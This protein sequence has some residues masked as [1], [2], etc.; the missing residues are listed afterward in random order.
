MLYRCWRYLICSTLCNTTAFGRREQQKFAF[1]SFSARRLTQR[2]KEKM[3]ADDE[4]GDASFLENFDPDAA[5]RQYEMEQKQQQESAKRRKLSLEQ[6]N[7]NN[8]KDDEVLLKTLMHYFGYN[9]F[10]GEQLPVIQALLQKRDC[11]VFWPTGFGKSLCYSLPPLHTNS[12]ALVVSPLISLMQDQVHKLNS[13]TE[14]KQ[15]AAFLGS[16]QTDPTVERAALAGDFP[17]VF[18]TPEKLEALYLQQLAPKLC[19][20]AID[21]AHCVSE[22]GHD[23]RPSYRAVGQQLRTNRN[24]PLSQVPIVALTATATPQ[25]QTDIVQSLHLRPNHLVATRSLDRP[26]LKLIV[27]KKLPGGVAANLVPAAKSW[28]KSNESTLIYAPTRSMVQDICHALQANHIPAAMYHA[29]M[30]TADRNTT[31]QQFLTSKLHILVATTAFGMGIDK[32]DIRRVVHYSPPKTVEEY[33]QQLGRA[34]RDGLAA[35]CILYY[36]GSA[37]FDRYQTDFYLQGLTPTAKQ[38]TLHSMSQLRN[39]CANVE[40]C[41]RQVLLAYFQQQQQ[42]PCGTSSLC[43]V[44]EAA[45]QYGDDQQRDFGP[46]GA[47]LVLTAVE[48]LDHQGATQIAKVVAGHVVESYRYARSSRDPAAAVQQRIVEMKEQLPQKYAAGYYKELLTQL[49]QKG[50]LLEST[51]TAVRDGFQRT[52][53]VYSLSPDKGLPALR[54]TSKPI[55]LPVPEHLRQLERQEA[56]RRQRVLAQ[57]TDRGLPPEKIPPAEVAVGDGDVIRA[58]SK[59]YAHVERQHDDKQK[60][61]LAALLEAMEQWRLDTAVEHNLAPASVLSEHLL[62]SIAYTAATL[63]AQVKL[64]KASLVAAGVRTRNVD[65]LVNVLCS[66]VE[67]HTAA[68][69][70]S[71]NTDGSGVMILGETRDTTAWRHAVYKPIKKTGLAAWEASYVR[72]AKGE[73]PQTIA[74]TPVPGKKPIQVKT[75]VSHLLD[76]ITHGRNVD[77]QQLQNYMAPPTAKEWEALRAAELATGMNACG[78]PETSGRNGDRFTMSEFLRPVVGNAIVDAPFAERSEADKEL[79]G[80]WCDMLKWYL[81]LRRAGYEPQFRDS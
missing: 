41:R 34:G 13:L 52:W 24:S 69:V 16:A 36:G 12:V 67:E 68:A 32:P 56:A 64:D 76:A 11:A 43:D 21:E 70:E 27:R 46:L 30:S 75:V 81:A 10:R 5:V 57:L 18:L 44:C 28:K 77:L 72:F 1:A 14:T 66:W 37:D 23:F 4:F 79:F 63:P 19:L 26:N 6:N 17:L 25:V 49:V 35:E 15:L 54:D 8:P 29:G 47:R 65:A 60:E 48:A 39:Y 74:M 42:Q 2:N 9:S 40:T 7:G 62:A 22:W 31:H 71:T 33:S 3:S 38:W 51:K 53:T 45:A 61:S 55:V 73:S 78:P 80:K 58:Y 50:Y 20:I 59:W